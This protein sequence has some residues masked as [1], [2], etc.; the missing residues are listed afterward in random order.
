MGIHRNDKIC[1]NDALQIVWPHGTAGDPGTL[2]TPHF[3]A[4]VDGIHC[5]INEPRHPELSKNPKFYSH[6]FH[7][8]ALNYEL[9]VSVTESRLLWMNGPFPASVHDV[10][11]FRRDLK[12]RV[13]RGG[14]LIG[15]KGYIGERNIISTPRSRDPQH[16]RKFKSRARARHE[17]PTRLVLSRI[18]RTP[19]ATQPFKIASL[20]LTY[21]K[22][23]AIRL[24]HLLYPLSYQIL[25]LYAILSLNSIATGHD[26]A[27]HIVNYC[28]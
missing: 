5:R 17:R 18:D 19:S 3:I 22:A 16:L 21:A 11:V 26:S 14:K 15:D 7:Q 9:A 13:P 4:T 27:K 1:T 28:S 8:A 20:Q 10:T 6:K 2:N 24:S 12:A 25:N 23:T